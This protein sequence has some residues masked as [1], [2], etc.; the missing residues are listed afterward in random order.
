METQRLSI[1]GMT[2]QGCVESVTHALRAIDGVRNVEVLLESGLA[3]IQI[4]EHL[5]SVAELEQAVE[6]TGYDISNGA[7]AETLQLKHKGCC[8]G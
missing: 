7:S 8:C 4:D 5:T 1:T 3:T 6:I 2:C